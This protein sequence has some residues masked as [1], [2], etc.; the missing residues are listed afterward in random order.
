YGGEAI[1]RTARMRALAHGGQVLVSSVTADVVGDR[2]P[3]R[4]SLVDLGVHRLKGMGRAQRVFQLQHPDLTEG[5]PPLRSLDMAKA[6]VPV[7]LTSL[8]GRVDELARGRSLLGDG[9]ARLVT[10]VGPG[11]CGK[12]RLA[13]TLANERGDVP[14]GEV[15]WAELASG[16]EPDAVAL[17]VMAVMGIGDTW[18]RT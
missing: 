17:A 8:I 10:L 3:E 2:L 5:F 11:G 9:G 4:A 12:T 18:G 6:T 1:I 14:D 13:A 15:W 16:T 7:V